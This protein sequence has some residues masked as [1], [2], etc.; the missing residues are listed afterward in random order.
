MWQGNE[1]VPLSMLTCKPPSTS[2]VCMQNWKYHSAYF[3]NT[4]STCR[5]N[6]SILHFGLAKV[7][8]RVGVIVVCLASG[9]AMLVL[10]RGQ[11]EFQQVIQRFPAIQIQLLIDSAGDSRQSQHWVNYTAFPGMNPGI[12]FSPAH[13]QVIIG[14][15]S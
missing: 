3:I 2:L 12:V 5:L 9:C 14:A 1:T 11:I 10:H 15:I 6:I 7:T 8:C 4:S 13:A